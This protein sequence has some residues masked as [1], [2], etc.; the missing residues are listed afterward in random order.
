M[1]GVSWVLHQLHPP[2]GLGIELRQA[3]VR[4]DG[5]GVCQ[6]QGDA[7]LDTHHIDGQDGQIILQ[8]RIHGAVQDLEEGVVKG[9]RHSGSGD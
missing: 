6:R 3:Q 9:E 8:P 4:V 2:D 1:T 7:V 5:A